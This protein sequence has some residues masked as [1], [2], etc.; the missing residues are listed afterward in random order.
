MTVLAAR[1]WSSN[2]ELFAD[3]SKLH[4]LDGSVMDCTYGLGLF[5]SLWRPESLV[6]HD[7][8]TVDGVD[9]RNLP[10]PD[11][12]FDASVLD[13]PY[14]MS[15]TRDRG[16]FDERYGVQGAYVKW[17]DVI[18]LVCDGISECLRATKP[19][20]YLLLKCADQVCSG[21]VRWQTRIFSDWAEAKGAKLVDRFD[22]IT[23]PRPQ[24][25]GR[26]QRH[27]AR[28]LSTLLVFQK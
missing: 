9:F 2:A 20:G 27:A 6:C 18:E 4:Y 15:G 13:P 21:Q 19:G 26:K 7:L 17:Q 10:E 24:P 5:W 12:T 11:G 28:N 14:R 22:M 1:A 23:T 16:D 25:A 8:Y 3:V